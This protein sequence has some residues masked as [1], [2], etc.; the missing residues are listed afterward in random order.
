MK[1]TLLVVLSLLVLIL[2][3]YIVYMHPTVTI[4]TL[5]STA[6]T[7]VPDH[8]ASAHE[9]RAGSTHFDCDNGLS[10][11][12]IRYVPTFHVT[13]VLSGTQS[14]ELWQSSESPFYTDDAGTT[15]FYDAGA[16]AYL[17]Q[18]GKLLRS[19]CVMNEE[20]SINN[21]GA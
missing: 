6:T 7:Q 1:N 8:S 20:K 12:V 3:G 5:E 4:P 19:T 21:Y 9:S 15:E 11:D 13:A 16:N 17:R 10:M 14:I 18:D 2:G